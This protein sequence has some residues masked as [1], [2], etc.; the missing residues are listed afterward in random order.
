MGYTVLYIAFGVVALWLLGEVLL[1]Y[2]ARLRWRLL[3]F[4]GFLGVVGGVSLRNAIV[5]A[6]G[7]VAFGTGQTFVTLSYRRGFSTGWALGGS[8][9]SSR[10]R[11]GTR[12][13]GAAMAAE[14]ILEVTPIEEVAE[15]PDPA[16]VYQSMP[17]LDD[18][19][20]YGIYDGQSSY[21]PD[22]YISSG[23]EGYGAEGYEGWGGGEPQQPQPAAATYEAYASWGGQQEYD[24]AHTAPYQDPGQQQYG[25]QYS[26]QYGYDTPP[27]GVWVPQ[28]QS[29]EPPLQDPQQQAYIPQQPQPPYEQSQYA[30]P[31]DPYRY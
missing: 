11:K 28:Q 1:Q 25:Q 16:Q 7:A 20:E 12:G 26:Q 27:G 4:A 5:I 29:A 15:G 31:Y 2:K 30:D 8:P 10:R 24:P 19:G 17:M 23:Y 3:A 6:L 18:T 9:G 21:T 22:P 14:P 13:A